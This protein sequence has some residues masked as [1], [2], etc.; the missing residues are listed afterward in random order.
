MKRALQTIVLILIV[1]VSHAQSV[2][3]LFDVQNYPTNTDLNGLLIDFIQTDNGSTFLLWRLNSSTSRLLRMN[4][5][6]ES[7]WVLPISF[8]LNPNQRIVEFDNKYWIGSKDGLLSFQEDGTYQL[9]TTAN[10]AIP[11]NDLNSTITDDGYLWIGTITNG[12]SRFDGTA[13]VNYSAVQGNL[14]TDSIFSLMPSLNSGFYVSNVDGFYRFNSSFGSSTLLC[15]NL[16]S[17]NAS[18]A[19]AV[20]ETNDDVF[21]VGNGQ[22]T[23]ISN[24]GTVDVNLPV[25]ISNACEENEPAPGSYRFMSI[26]NKFFISYSTD[27]NS[28][29]VLGY[30]PEGR[31]F[32]YPLIDRFPNDYSKSIV[33]GRLLNVKS[34][35][36][37][38]YLSY[39][40]I[41]LSVIKISPELL[42]IQA[43]RDY[44][45]GSLVEQTDLNDFQSTHHV[46]GRWNYNQ[47][48]KLGLSIPKCS[49]RAATAMSSF[50]IGGIDET[51]IVHFSGDLL[52]SGEFDWQAGPL[53][54]NLAQSNEAL[55]VKYSRAWKL[56]RMMIDNFI[57]AF[58]NGQVSSGV[59]QVP[60]DIVSYPGNPEP[61]CGTTVAPYFDFN[62]D[63]IYNAMDGDY[64]EIDGDQQIISV[65]NDAGAHPNSLE[66]GMGVEVWHFQT[67][68]T[69]EDISGEFNNPENSVNTSI[70][71]K[72]KIINK[73]VIDYDSVY[74]GVGTSMLQTAYDYFIGT[75]AEKNT[76]YYT[77]ALAQDTLYDEG[78]PTFGVCILDGPF[79]SPFDEIDNDNDGEIDEDDE[80]NLLTSSILYPEWFYSNPNSPGRRYPL[81]KSHW[82]SN[83]PLTYGGNGINTGNATPF[84]YPGLPY[85]TNGWSEWSEDNQPGNRTGIAASG[86]FT[87]GAMESVNFSFAEVFYYKPGGSNGIST[88]WITFNEYID[89]VRENYSS[90]TSGSCWA[91]I[92]KTHKVEGLSNTIKV[93]PVP[94]TNSISIQFEKDYNQVKAIQIYSIDGRLVKVQSMKNDT[95]I[96]ISSL[97][98]GLYVIRTELANVSY[99]ARFVKL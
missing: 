40:G 67:S 59:Y 32:C 74:V 45:F 14:S 50:W 12:I 80:K 64:P 51:G 73:S 75:I 2:Q 11:S 38:V 22:V 86:P 39:S 76:Q 85:Q 10:S 78:V 29:G 70:I 46:L 25:M 47:Y 31:S 8:G 60:E 77:G 79:S 56:D 36:T 68:T 30:T 93:Y 35:D 84:I 82:S 21:F 27:T 15:S 66:T 23:R 9:Y 57:Y 16:Q 53:L 89:M 96:D 91:Y 52:E 88:S 42:D 87:L 33:H 83:N 34:S 4:A 26:G 61:G 13:F 28:D 1:E 81:M 7:E 92:A 5:A 24:S 63:G 55:K 54:E 94:A 71:H 95:Q 3:S 97:N 20:I 98:P 19:Q 18:I 17:T 49:Y 6:G 90:N 72:F 65:M 62:N 43:S 99:N 41:E 48:H 37:L 44:G 69:C 58:A